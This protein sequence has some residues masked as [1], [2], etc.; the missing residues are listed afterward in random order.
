MAEGDE[1]PRG[2]RGLPPGNVFEMNMRRDAIWC[3]LRHN[4]EK[5]SSV[6]TDLVASG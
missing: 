6:C 2:V 5:C 4:F 1:L 3:I